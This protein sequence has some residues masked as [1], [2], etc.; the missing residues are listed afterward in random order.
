MMWP[1]LT[2]NEQSYCRTCKLCQFNKKTR[3]HVKQA[4]TKNWEIVEVHL[5]GPWK[6]KTPSGTKTLR[7]FTAIYPATPWP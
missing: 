2:R 6:V 5:V 7:C 1:G 3:K 4:E